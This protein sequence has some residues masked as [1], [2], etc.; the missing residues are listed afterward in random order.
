MDNLA[1]PSQIMVSTNFRI[2]NIMPNTRFSE[3]PEQAQKE[4]VELERYIRTEGQRCEYISKRG[5]RQHANVIEAAKSQTE[6][7]SQVFK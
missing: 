1:R 7:L 5:A 4:L 2:D 3:L 6:S